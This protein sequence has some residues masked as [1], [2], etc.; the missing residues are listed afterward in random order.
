MDTK[1]FECCYE[2]HKLAVFRA[3]FAY[4]RNRA[5]AEDILQET[6]LKRFRYDKDFQDAEA[7]KA[8][9]LR[10]A[11]NA[12][13]DLLKSARRRYDVPLEEA[14]TMCETPDERTVTEAIMQLDP[15]YRMP[16]HLYY[17]EGYTVPEIGS[18]LGVSETAVQTRL[19]RARKLLR[20][21]LGK[22]LVL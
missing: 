7:E 2:R 11:V 4:C 21:A 13:K 10:V 6:F 19:Y 5:D 12:S 20:N 1:D 16:V 22:E 17:I 18:I 15:K 8:W 9:L 14:L 3:A